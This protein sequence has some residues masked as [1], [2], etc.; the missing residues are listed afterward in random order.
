M[1]LNT[2]DYL[3]KALLDTQ[4]RVRDF[5]MY[6]EKAQSEDIQCFFRQYAESEA[7]QAAQLQQYIDCLR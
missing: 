7:Y 2:Q 6:A 5:M 1:Q 4:E 3:K